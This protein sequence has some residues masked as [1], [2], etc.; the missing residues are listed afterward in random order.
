M[1]HL[2]QE[3]LLKNEK[4]TYR[5]LLKVE[6]ILP[7]MIS[8]SKLLNDTSSSN[9]KLTSSQPDCALFSHPHRY[10]LKLIFKYFK[11]FIF[12]DINPLHNPTK[13]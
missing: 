7:P 6:I 2:P 3:S 11:D 13:K 5:N 10:G 12:E 1:H 8:V 9:S 4:K